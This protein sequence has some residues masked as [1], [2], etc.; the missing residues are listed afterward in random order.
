MDSTV[1]RCRRVMGTSI[2][3]RGEH[4]ICKGPVA[5]RTTG[6]HGSVVPP[7]TGK[8]IRHQWVRLC[9]EPQRQGNGE[10]GCLVETARTRRHDPVCTRQIHDRSR[11]N[12]PTR[13]GGHHRKGRALHDRAW[14]KSAGE[15]TAH[16]SGHRGESCF[17][18]PAGGGFAVWGDRGTRE[19]KNTMH[20]SW[21]AHERWQ[22]CV[23]GRS[24]P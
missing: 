24:I 14:S 12:C 13:H 23:V 1:L 8:S 20:A 4:C 2:G 6:V 3:Q 19:W 9:G 22:H 10:H 21:C 5:K 16:G 18:T 11:C 7:R 17:H 15:R